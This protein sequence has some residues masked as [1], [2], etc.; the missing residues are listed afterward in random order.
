MQNISWF[1]ILK[2]LDRYLHNILQNVYGQGGLIETVIIRF[3]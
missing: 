1:I 3:K 2:S